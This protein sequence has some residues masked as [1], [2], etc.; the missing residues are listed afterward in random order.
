M[1]QALSC[2]CL[3][4]TTACHYMPILKIYWWQCLKY[5]D[6]DEIN[7]EEQFNTDHNGKDI[8]SSQQ[9]KLLQS[10]I[11]NGNKSDEQLNDGRKERLIPKSKYHEIMI[12]YNQ[13]FWIYLYITDNL[14]IICIYDIIYKW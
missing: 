10:T 12:T 8:N 2:I 4:T 11:K 6:V 3:D 1:K 5:E 9:N 7:V 13:G 14:Y